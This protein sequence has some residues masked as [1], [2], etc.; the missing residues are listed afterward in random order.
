[1]PLRTLLETAG[2]DQVVL[3]VSNFY[4]K[5]NEDVQEFL[6][7]KAIDFEYKNIGRTYLFVDEEQLANDDVIA[8]LGYFTITMKSLTFS[9]D[10]SKTCRKRIT[11]NK[12]ADQAVGYLIGQLGKNDDYKDYISGQELVETALELID[13]LFEKLGGR[14]VLVECEDDSKLIQFYE[15]L[16]FKIIQEQGLV[17]L[18]RAL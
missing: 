2:R 1:L 7:S 9:E 10:V 17:Q 8:I 15:R 11:S 4:C 13:E 3:A 6:R 18:Y 16:D 5:R 12:Y 14:F